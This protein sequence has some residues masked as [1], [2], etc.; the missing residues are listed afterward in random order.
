MC[1]PGGELVGGRDVFVVGEDRSQHSGGLVAV[2][3]IHD[4]GG[5]R[6]FLDVFV[7]GCALVEVS[8][9]GVAA[10]GEGDVGQCASGGFAEDCVDG[11]GGD[12]LSGVHG[13]GVAVGD[14]RTDVVGVEDRQRVVVEAAGG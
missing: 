7:F 4:M 5:V 13:N 11:V 8:G 1:R 2:A 10:A 14:V 9:V 6:R 3:V 12:T